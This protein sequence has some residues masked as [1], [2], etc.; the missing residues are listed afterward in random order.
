MPPG[1]AKVEQD[2]STS[3]GNMVR[4]EKAAILPWEEPAILKPATPPGPTEE[5]RSDG[6][7]NVLFVV[8]DDLRPTLSIYE[9][10][11]VQSPN[12]ERLAARGL[13]LNRAY[14]QVPH[15]F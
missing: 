12:I 13:I 3:A 10:S 6:R 8:A 1:V 2:G 5:G 11:Y 14:A 4:Q 9:K 15:S 7:M